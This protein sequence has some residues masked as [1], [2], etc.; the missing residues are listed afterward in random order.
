MQVSAPQT[1]THENFHPVLGGPLLRLALGGHDSCSPK[2][3]MMKYASIICSV[4]VLAAC[5]SCKHPPDASGG[6]VSGGIDNVI[7]GQVEH[8]KKA[9][10][11]IGS[12]GASNKVISTSSAEIE[13]TPSKPEPVADAN[14]RIHDA[15]RDIDKDMESVR[16]ALKDIG[17][18]AQKVAGMGSDVRKLEAKIAD[19]QKTAEI[20]ENENAKKLYDYIAL[21]WVA[22]FLLIAGGIALAF[23]INRMAG[24]A[25]ALTGVIVLGLASASQYYLKEIAQVGFVMLIAGMVGGVGFLVYM[26]WRQKRTDVALSE[27][28]EM[29]DELK[30][31]LTEEQLQKTF[32]DNGV[33]MNLYS[34]ATRSLV[35]KKRSAVKLQDGYH[36]S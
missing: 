5:C 7:G 32:G 12:I 3:S 30:K 29:V 1:A 10:T 27:V 36:A 23:F 25:I 8:I 13:V 28:V 35:D 15:S 21:F 6:G 18:S 11:A 17:T 14:R 31:D 20:L 4:F 34:S 26:A 16:V 2:M 24:G 19:L 33:A 22:G 9:E